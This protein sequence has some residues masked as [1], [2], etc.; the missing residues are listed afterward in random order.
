MFR[1]N[2]ANLTFDCSDISTFVF[3]GTEDNPMDPEPFSRFA[4]V[5]PQQ[6][7]TSP[8]DSPFAASHW[9]NS[10]CT[11]GQLTAKGAAQHQTLGK[12]L[13]EIYVD[14][15]K[16]LP[17]EFDHDLFYIRS[18]DVWRTMQSAE[19]LMIGLYG[20]DAQSRNL[21]PP[22]FQTHTFPSSIEYL[23]MNEDQCPRIKDL[24]SQ[25]TE[26]NNE[27]LQNIYQDNK[28]FLSTLSD[29]FGF[30]GSIDDYIGAV[31]P[32]YCHNLPLQCQED[33]GQGEEN[34][35]KEKDACATKETIDRL[36][37]IAASVTAET[38]RDGKGVHEILQ[39]GMGPLAKDIQRNVQNAVN[40]TDKS[41]PRFRLYSG[42]DSMIQ[43]MLGVLD[44]LDMNWPPYV[45]NLLIEV[46]KSPSS[47]SSSSGPAAGEDYFVRVMYNSRI[48]QTKSQWCDLSWCPL[49]KFVE[50][51]DRFVVKDLLAQCQPKKQPELKEFVDYI[52]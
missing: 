47:S 48:L 33:D 18:T 36:F 9:K 11:L 1:P 4:R 19:S 14:Q 52:N 44:S 46:W 51:L 41:G 17:T 24:Q 21:P 50:Y 32:R 10:S 42:H 35:L 3:T 34:K 30:K 20:M 5:V 29:L 49:N 39:L 27:V 43:P 25:Y 16:F 8:V 13:R 40:L 6:V 12:S 23:T 22:T 37:S 38:L 26:R 7:V 45:S 28:S 2:D 15:W 31:M